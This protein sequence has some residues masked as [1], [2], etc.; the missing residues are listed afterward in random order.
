MRSSNSNILDESSS[1][2]V[3]YSDYINI[4]LFDVDGALLRDG[5]QPS[6]GMEHSLIED[7]TG[8]FRELLAEYDQRKY[9]KI[10]VGSGTNRQDQTV[11]NENRRKYR[12][13]YPSPAEAPFAPVLPII[14]SHLQTCLDAEGNP[15]EV[16]MDPIMTA[17]IFEDET[18]GENFKKLLRK[19]YLQTEEDHGYCV[20]D[21]T[22]ILSIILAA[23][24]AA[25]LN[26]N[27]KFVLEI[28][29]DKEEGIL[30]G[31]NTF[32]GNNPY[33]LPETVIFRTQHHDGQQR[34]GRF[35]NQIGQDIQGTASTIDVHYKW[36]I[37]YL[38]ALIGAESGVKP[39]MNLAAPAQFALYHQ[40][41]SNRVPRENQRLNRN[42]SEID[43]LLPQH[44][45]AD[46]LDEVKDFIASRASE[47]D[48]LVK[49]TAKESTTPYTT[50]AELCNQ[51]LLPPRFV[52]GTEKAKIASGAE[53]WN[54]RGKPWIDRPAVRLG[55]KIAAI[56]AVGAAIGVVVYFTGGLG[57]IAL[58]IVLKIAVAVAAGAGATSFFASTAET[59][60]DFFRGSKK[61]AA[62]SG[63][64]AP[65]PVLEK[66]AST[67][68]Q[69]VIAPPG[70]ALSDAIDIIPPSPPVT[71]VV[72]G[73]GASIDSGLPRVTGVATGSSVPLPSGS[74]Q[75]SQLSSTAVVLD[76]IPPGAQQSAQA[77]PLVAVKLSRS[78]PAVG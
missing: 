2:P 41:K 27:E 36:T 9:K 12:V 39:S 25:A 59:V 6:P 37:R 60:I 48:T 7:N 38:V 73:S 45:T 20:F 31:L 24:R 56:V 71:G 55:L 43:P 18:P 17:D 69:N 22:K 14:Q 1:S 54:N 15:C 35:I 3:D 65:Q 77:Q 52:L 68:E 11:D 53:F 33:F 44:F 40:E 57:L 30:R 10:I 58:P 50:A 47:M 74:S 66:T 13:R 21:E 42:Y 67:V 16:V 28:Y 75:S 32:F 4:K 72:G 19:E 26:P 78:L 29:D 61:P 8:F 46:I 63:I 70:S 64:S 51:G 23:S 49:E 62:S 5:E 76:V 34:N